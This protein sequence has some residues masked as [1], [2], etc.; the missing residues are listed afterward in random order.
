[1]SGPSPLM[2]ALAIAGIFVIV[3]GL[4]GS[5]GFSCSEK[6]NNA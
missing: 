6:K 4:L 2:D 1:M 5:A 3:V